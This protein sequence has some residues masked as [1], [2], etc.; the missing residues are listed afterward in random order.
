MFAAAAPPP[1]VAGHRVA[2][3]DYRPSPSEKKKETRERTEGS[4]EI[5]R[6]SQNERKLGLHPIYSGP[7][8]D[9]F[10][11]TQLQHKPTQF[12]SLKPN[13][14]FYL[15]SA[16]LT[17]CLHP[18]HLISCHF[19]A[20]LNFPL[21]FTFFY[22]VIHHHSHVYFYALFLFYSHLFRM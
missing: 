3:S 9:P 7:W 12:G 2:T 6:V 19:H 5:E 4:E 10:Q 21:H 22:V 13:P 11:P 18:Q 20:F 15:F 8:T 14:F 16:P 17:H 1:T